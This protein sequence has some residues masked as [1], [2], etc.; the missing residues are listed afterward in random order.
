MVDHRHLHAVRAHLLDMAGDTRPLTSYQR[1]TRLTPS[2][3]EQH[4]LRGRLLAQ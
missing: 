4:Y 3:P 1:A 2:I